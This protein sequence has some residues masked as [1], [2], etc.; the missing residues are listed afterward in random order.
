MLDH[1]L[2][3]L[4]SRREGKWFFGIPTPY[5]DHG[6]SPTALT[7]ITEVLI[8]ANKNSSTARRKKPTPRAD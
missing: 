2:S 4:V 8:E 7:R 1:L 6:P 5:S 3:V